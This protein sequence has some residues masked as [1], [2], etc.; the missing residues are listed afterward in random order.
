MCIKERLYSGACVYGTML[1]VLDSPDLVLLLK[2]CG[3]DWFFFDAEHGCPEP[4]RLTAMFT[5]ARL[6][7][8]TGLLRIPE[9]NRVEVLRALD[10]GAAGLIVPNVESAAQAAELVRLSKYAPQGDRGVSLSR[11]HSGY[12]SVDGP[13]FMREANRHILLVPQIESPQGVAQV[14]EI[15]AVEGIDGVLIG[16]G[17][18]SQT[19]GIFGQTEDPRFLDCCRQVVESC[20]THGKFAGIVDKSPQRLRLWRSRGFRFLQLGSD[21]SLLGNAIRTGLAA[22]KA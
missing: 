10:M 4:Q 9:L 21:V 20:Q 8:L 22:A 7:D 16:P 18:L 12:R 11:P 14:D 5:Y 1:G 15:T 13:T 17:D 6:C 3:M 19:L 2:E